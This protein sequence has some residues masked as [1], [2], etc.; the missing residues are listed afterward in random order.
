MS[1]LLLTASL[2]GGFGWLG[3]R[4]ATASPLE[5]RPTA[6]PAAEDPQS[7]IAWFRGSYEALMTTARKE[8]KLVLL[9][10]WTEW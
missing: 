1:T 8:G 5:E 10:F 4:T 9:D 7:E 2:L 6:T 3:P